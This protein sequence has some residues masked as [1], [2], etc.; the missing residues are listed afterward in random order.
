V[1]I[2]PLVDP[3]LSM[4]TRSAAFVAVLILAAEPLVAQQPSLGVTSSVTAAPFRYQVGR[5][6]TYVCPAITPTKD[7]AVWGTDIYTYDSSVC[8]AAIHAGVL[9]AQQAASVTFTMGPGDASFRGSD[10]NGVTSA[11]YTGYDSS[12]TFDKSS[13]PGRIDGL[14]TMR[15][16]DGFTGSVTVVCP[17]LGNFPQPLWGTDVYADDSSICA[18]AAHYGLITLNA[19]G[20]VV[21]TPA[22]PQSAFKGM[23]RNN[24]T[25]KDYPNWPT[26]FRVG[27]S[28]PVTAVI[29]TPQP[30]TLTPIAPTSVPVA[31]PTRT[32]AAPTSAGNPSAAAAAE[33]ISTPPPRT[34]GLSGFTGAGRLNAVIPKTIDVVPGFTGSGSSTIVATRTITLTGFTATGPGTRVNPRAPTAGARGSPAVAPRTITLGGFAAV[35]TS[36]VAPPRIIAL[37]GFTATGSHTVAPPRTID[38]AGFTATGDQQPP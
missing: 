31:A 37:T 38:L 30:A 33:R 8:L 2:A 10:S 18:A 13:E 35:G 36:S 14:T 6:I 4:A 21:V 29:M 3:D 32:T 25:S 1:G 26:S 24:V 22:G 15:M 12:F 28:G 23:V 17:A 7:V 27:P 5:R 19:G 16:P 34:I 9:R 20:P 11:P